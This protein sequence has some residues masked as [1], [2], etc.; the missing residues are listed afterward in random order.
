MFSIGLNLIDTPPPLEE[1]GY[2]T[3]LLWRWLAEKAGGRWLEF[4]AY[5]FYSADWNK[6]RMAEYK[7][8]IL[9]H[10]ERGDVDLIPTF[11]TVAGLALITDGHQTSVFSVIA[12]FLQRGGI[13]PTGPNLPE[14]GYKQVKAHLTLR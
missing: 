1:D 14:S 11:G 5:G 12:V 6:A 4:L 10:L 7:L 3:A 13:Y 2:D 8:D 9:T